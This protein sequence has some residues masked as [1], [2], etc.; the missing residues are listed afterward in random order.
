MVEIAALETSF[1]KQIS[2]NK[3]LIRIKHL[4][5]IFLRQFDSEEFRLVCKYLKHILTKYNEDPFEIYEILLCDLE[6]QGFYE[7]NLDDAEKEELIKSFIIDDFN[8]YSKETDS[9]ESHQDREEEIKSKKSQGKLNDKIQ[10][11]LEKKFQIS[12]DLLS[13]NERKSLAK[14]LRI[15]EKQVQKWFVERRE[16]KSQKNSNKSKTILVNNE[17]LELN[18]TENKE[19]DL[20]SEKSE[21]MG[22]TR[23]RRSRRKMDDEIENEVKQ[24]DSSGRRLS[25]RRQSLLDKKEIEKVEEIQDV[26]SPPSKRACRSYSDETIKKLEDYFEQDNQADENQLKEIEKETNLSEY[27]IKKWFRQKRDT[28]KKSSRK[29]ITNKRMSDDR[30]E[31]KEEKDSSEK[32]ETLNSNQNLEDKSNDKDMEFIKNFSK[33]A[34]EELEKTFEKSANLRPLDKKA[35]SLRLGLKTIDIERWFYFK[36]KEQ[37]ETIKKDQD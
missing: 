6:K 20:N 13:A 18:P 35:L 37:Q 11:E 33:E 24:I 27:L 29:S 26:Q 34:I 9:D 23:G 14:K 3:N 32:N 8:F 17:N 31:I 16:Q 36:R 2:S 30:P 28:Q 10:A 12:G 21:S 7:S 25:L 22:K 4:L 19:N 5:I 15:S 1:E